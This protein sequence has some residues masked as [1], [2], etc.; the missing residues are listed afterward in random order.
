MKKAKLN[1]EGMRSELSESQ[2]FRPKRHEGME[3]PAEPEPSPSPRAEERPYGRT[4]YAILP[5]LAW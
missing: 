4:G 3:R 5:F 2:F 1:E